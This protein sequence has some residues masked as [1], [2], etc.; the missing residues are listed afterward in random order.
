MANRGSSHEHEYAS[1]I[2][3]LACGGAAPAESDRRHQRG[4]CAGNA[5]RRDDS[6]G[7]AARHVRTGI[8]DAS[9]HNAAGPATFDGADPCALRNAAAFDCT[10]QHALGDAAAFD[11]ANQCT[12]G[13]AAIFDGANQ[14]TLDGAATFDGIRQ[15][16]VG[17]A[18]TLHCAQQFAVGR[19]SNFHRA[20]RQSPRSQ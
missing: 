11:G 4:V 5:E 20:G 9:A 16:A 7:K 1:Q 3:R 19:A 13:D 10:N 14:C 15:H 17:L 12:L 18:A 8:A 6:G 2:V